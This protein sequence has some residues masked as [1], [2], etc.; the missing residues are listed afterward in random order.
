MNVFLW[1]A[2]ERNGHVE[3]TLNHP[4]PAQVL[5]ELAR[6]METEQEKVIPFQAN[7]ANTE[8]DVAM[9][10]AQT[11]SQKDDWQEAEKQAVRANDDD[12]EHGGDLDRPLDADETTAALQTSS[13]TND[14]KPVAEWCHL[15][16]FLRKYNKVLLDKLAIERE[17]E[18]LERENG[19]LQT[20]LKQYFDGVSVNDAVMR[21]ANPLFVVNGKLNISQPLPVRRNPDQLTVVDANHMVTTSRV[22]TTY[23]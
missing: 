10:A 13:W 4:F 8:A 19:D 11:A 18:R 22:N 16:N 23:F 3:A 9:A 14:G 5:A 6:K 15:D 2:R 1:N 7:P 20:I 12:V 17:R 21:S